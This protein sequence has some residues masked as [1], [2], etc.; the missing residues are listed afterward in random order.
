M[1]F[2]TSL[3]KLSVLFVISSVVFIVVCTIGTFFVPLLAFF[4]GLVVNYLLMGWPFAIAIIILGPKRSASA[5][6]IGNKFTRKAI[7][8]CATLLLLSSLTRYFTSF[9]DQG[10]PHLV[11]LIGSLGIL[12]GGVLLPVCL[13][14][15][16]LSKRRDM[17]RT[18]T[19]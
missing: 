16:L 15:E 18:L 17:S 9:A 5:A 6:V 2:Q 7:V 8:T 4:V 14:V 1:P 12:V 13:T 3:Y 10:L 11:Y 19:E